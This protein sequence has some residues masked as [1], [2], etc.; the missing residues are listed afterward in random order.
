MICN[1]DLIVTCVAIN[2][3]GSVCRP[4]GSVCRLAAGFETE[5]SRG[6]RIS[7]MFRIRTSQLNGFPFKLP[8]RFSY[9]NRMIKMMICLSR[10]SPVH[11]SL[12]K[13][14]N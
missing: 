14:E 6:F 9:V 5:K 4:T 13:A 7:L 3:T 8:V 10:S 12:L 1:N 2:T 11:V